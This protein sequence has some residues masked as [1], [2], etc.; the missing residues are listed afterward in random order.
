M[1]ACDR[2]P[3]NDSSSRLMHVRRVTHCCRACC[4]RRSLSAGRRS[5][6]LSVSIRIPRKTRV[7]AGPSVLCVAIGIPTFSNGCKVRDRTS[8]P[9]GE[10][11]G[12]KKRKSSR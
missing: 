8:R 7:V 4:S 12:A 10:L 1:A 2:W 3:N 9:C 6:K 11:G 5:S